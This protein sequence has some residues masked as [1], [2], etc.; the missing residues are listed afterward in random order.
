VFELARSPASSLTATSG[1]VSIA[2]R[3]ASDGITSQYFLN[4]TISAGATIVEAPTAS[5]PTVLKTANLSFAG[6]TGAWGGSLD[7]TDNDFVLEFSK[8]TFATVNSLVAQGY[9]GGKWDGQGISS[10]TAAADTT[11]LTAIGVIPNYSRV[12]YGTNLFDGTAILSTSDILLKYTYYRDANLDGRVDGSDYTR[13]DAGFASKGSLTGWYNGD[14]NYDGKVDGSDYT[15]I[16]N[17]FNRQTVSLAALIAPAVVANPAAVLGTVA[18]PLGS[19]EKSKTTQFPASPVKRDAG[20][21]FSTAGMPIL[22]GRKT[23]DAVVSPVPKGRK[24]RGSKPAFNFTL[25]DPVRSTL[26]LNK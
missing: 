22:A 2:P 9:D 17:A 8:V 5:L 3:F 6:T 19:V 11:H 15:L 1:V 16:D 20:S 12:F 23:E 4:L 13:I 10:S 18:V 21:T 14:F 7:L 25:S 26:D 24:P